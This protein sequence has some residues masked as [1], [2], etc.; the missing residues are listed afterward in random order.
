MRGHR[1]SYQ[2]LFNDTPPVI[3]TT[4][5]ERRGR[6][7]QL[8]LAQNELL[9]CRYYYHV[10]I[11]GLKYLEALNI[12]R[13]EVFLEIRTIQDILAKENAHLK[14]LHQAAP[15]IKYFQKKYSWINW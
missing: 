14:M 10:K 13:F 6:S 8:K 5:P 9:V 4:S 7:E 12:L 15:D 2:S 3:E 1:T 11:K